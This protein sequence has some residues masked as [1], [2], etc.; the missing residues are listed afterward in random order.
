MRRV[1]EEMVRGQADEVVLEA[2]VCNE[3]PSMVPEF[4]GLICGSWSSHCMYMALT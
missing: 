4:R 2:E 3:S 1:V